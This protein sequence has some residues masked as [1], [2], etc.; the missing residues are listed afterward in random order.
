MNSISAAIVLLTGM[1]C[2]LGVH[3]N[4]WLGLS[5]GVILFLTGLIRWYRSWG[6]NSRD[7]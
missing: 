2:L 1:I 7:H 5:V 3:P 4:N 6:R